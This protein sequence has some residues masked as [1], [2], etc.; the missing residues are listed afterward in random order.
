M[1]K[2]LIELQKGCKA[3]CVIVL[4]NDYKQLS[5]IISMSANVSDKFL[6]GA[7]D[8]PFAEKLTNKCVNSKICYFV[9]KGIDLISTDAQNRFTSLVKDRELNGYTLPDNCIIVFTV[10]SEKTIKNISSDLYKFAV[11]AI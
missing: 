8:P 3:T 4:D 1:N 7:G 6:F 5:P 9:I 2:I 10:Q 11:V